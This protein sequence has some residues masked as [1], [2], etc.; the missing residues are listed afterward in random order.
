MVEKYYNY[1]DLKVKRIEILRIDNMD[2]CSHNRGGRTVR[3]LNIDRTEHIVDPQII[4]FE[5]STALLPYS[6]LP[7]SCISDQFVRF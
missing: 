6:Y 3:L 7:T 5:M 4:V 1:R 2:N